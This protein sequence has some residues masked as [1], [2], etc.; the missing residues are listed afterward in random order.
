MNR[1]GILLWCVL[2]A[3]L[4]APSCNRYLDVKPDK[5]LAVP[6]T[7][8]DCQA[9]LN[10]YNTM[11]IGYPSVNI[12]AADDHYLA[13][14]SWNAVSSVES[15]EN[16]VWSPHVP[17]VVNHWLGPYKAVYQSNQVLEILEGMEEKT[18]NASYY[19]AMASALFFRAFAFHQLATVFAP[20]YEKESATM[21]LGI[22]LR[23]NAG[24]DYKTKRNTLEETYVRIV[25]D[26]K[27][28]LPHLPFKAEQKT[29]PS[30]AAAFAALSRVYLDMSDYANAGKYA[31]SCLW[32]HD[33]LMD[34]N[35]LDAEVS[36]PI[37]R[38]NAEVLFHALAYPD[39]A[40]SPSLAL[41]DSNLIATYAATDLRKPV[42]FGAGTNPDINTH[43]FFKGS[44]DGS[45]TGLFIGLT[46]SEILLVR[47]ECRMR[48][49]DAAGAISDLNTLLTKRFESGQ[50]EPIS[51]SADDPLD[52]ILKERR[53]ELV[54][55]GRRWADLRRLNMESGFETELVRELDET[56]YR[57]PP[58]DPRYV[59]LIPQEVIETSDIAQNKR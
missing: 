47:S 16:Y 17:P 2:P 42:F 26:L 11:N 56:S 10:D 20:V 1:F 35:G 36:V 5:S 12:A 30:Q 25:E 24:L 21:V 13:L 41:I 27:A 52:I 55:R 8:A 3:I 14:E 29:K 7:L 44:Y 54:F 39:P 43:R 53:K 32:L 48:L 4:A 22:P 6:K 37:G 19:Q 9:L 28:A 15:R 34:F 23:L 45:T 57:L 33:D 31:D 50:F 51:A 59:M 46:T 49:G 40:L 38:F 18:R 58:N